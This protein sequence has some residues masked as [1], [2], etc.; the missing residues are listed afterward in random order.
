MCVIALE[1]RIRQSSYAS[2]I[3]RAL[4]APRAMQRSA[5]LGPE[6]WPVHASLLFTYHPVSDIA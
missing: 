6:A 1:S 5:P 2:S 3:T 4:R